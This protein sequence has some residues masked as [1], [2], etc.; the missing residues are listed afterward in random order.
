M[1]GKKRRRPWV[2]VGAEW[3]RLSLTSAAIDFIKSRLAK[4][5]DQEAKA[6]S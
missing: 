3:Q 2:I 4:K 6:A 1:V 5:P